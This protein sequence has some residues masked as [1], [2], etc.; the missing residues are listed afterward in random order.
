MG[1]TRAMFSPNFPQADPHCWAVSWVANLASPDKLSHLDVPS[2]AKPFSLLVV[3]RPDADLLEVDDVAGVVVLKADVTF[4]RPL[5]PALRLV[6]LL[7]LG[8][9]LGVGV[10]GA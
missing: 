6:P 1:L 8:D 5:R 10:E 3:E 7:L 2:P 4:Q 9:V